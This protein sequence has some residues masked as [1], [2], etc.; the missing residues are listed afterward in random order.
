MQSVVEEKVV[1]IDMRGCLLNRQYVTIYEP[2]STKDFVIN[3]VVTSIQMQL[4]AMVRR[5]SVAVVF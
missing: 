2:V 5:N 3:G 1:L 4:D